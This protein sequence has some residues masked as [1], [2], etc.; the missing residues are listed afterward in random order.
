MVLQHLEINPISNN[1]ISKGSQIL[2]SI[3][4]IFIYLKVVPLN[5][6]QAF[7]FFKTQKNKYKNSEKKLFY[8]HIE[9]STTKNDFTSFSSI[10][11]ISNLDSDCIY[12]ENEVDKELIFMLFRKKGFI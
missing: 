7:I 11:R 12:T 2:K 8:F 9:L 6:A 5:E 4:V 10:I 1:I 3:S